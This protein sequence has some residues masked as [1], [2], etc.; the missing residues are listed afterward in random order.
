MDG[1]GNDSTSQNFNTQDG[2]K[3]SNPKSGYGASRDRSKEGRA[4]AL[5]TERDAGKRCARSQE[6]R[7]QADEREEDRVIAQAVRGAQFAPQ[8]GRLPLRAVDAD[9]LYQSRR[10]DPAKDATR[11]A[12]AREGGVEA[13]VRE[14]IILVVPA[15]AGTYNHRCPCCK[16]LRPP[17]AATTSIRGYGS[18]HARG[19]QITPRGYLP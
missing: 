13:P 9:L 3:G 4:E 5:V 6:G 16:T 18:P 19:R 10:Q 12:G 14:G 15:N 17:V 2:A 11:P 7:V 8:D 1:V